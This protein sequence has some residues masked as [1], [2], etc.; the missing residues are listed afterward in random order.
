M[1]LLW[2]HL[3]DVCVNLVYS[4]YSTYSTYSCILLYTLCILLYTPV[5]SC[6]LSQVL[7]EWCDSDIEG[8]S[9]REWV[10]LT[11]SDKFH[12]VYLEQD[13]LWARRVLPSEQQRAVA[14]PAKVRDTSVAS[15]GLI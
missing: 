11:N 12:S 14:W 1:I 4:A 3:H 6:I 2:L 13:L 15:S 10:D 9:Q 7:L 5:Y 8:G